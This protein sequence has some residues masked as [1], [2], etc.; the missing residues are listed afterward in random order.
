MYDSGEKGI[1]TSSGSNFES[2]LIEKAGGEN[3]FSDIT[4]K[5]WITVSS[6]EVLARNPEIIIVHDYDSPS[7]EFKIEQIRK[8]PVLSQTDAVKNDKIFA[9]SL[10]NALPGPRMADT[11][12]TFYRE[13][14]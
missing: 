5:E 10:E 1:F 12:E 13:F 14:Q 2:L 3:I 7:V 4:E 8:D 6:E 11:V 9:I